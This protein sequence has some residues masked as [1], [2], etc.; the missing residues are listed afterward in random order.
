M[1]SSLKPRGGKRWPR[2]QRFNLSA[3]G[4]EA[5]AACRA[6]VQ[7]ARAQGRAALE[8]AQRGWAA[9]LGVAPG[10]GVVLAE[11]R[12]GRKSIAD[13]SHALETSGMGAT[14][15]KET[16]DRLVD[17]GMV[18]PAVAPEPQQVPASP[19]S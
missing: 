16:I 7:E 19:F 9:P 11:L 12:P 3:R 18:E 2:G 6:A 10:D 15:V 8:A 13:V 14:E 5:E 4:V 1:L 17:A